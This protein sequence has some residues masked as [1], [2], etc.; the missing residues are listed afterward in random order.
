KRLIRD[1]THNIAFT[2]ANQMRNQ[3][4]DDLNGKMRFLMWHQMKIPIENRFKNE[5]MDE[6]HV[7]LWDQW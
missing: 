6:L 5:V 4:E 1:S 3:M 7:P 2:F